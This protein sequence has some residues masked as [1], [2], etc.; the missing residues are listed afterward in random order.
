ME[1][2]TVRV[3]W[4][5]VVKEFLQLRRDRRM[6]PMIFLAPVV[7]ILAFG[8]AVN[9]DVTDVPTLLVDLDRTRA[10]RDLAERFFASGYFRLAG[11][12]DAAAAAEPWMVAGR[13]QMA[14]VIGRGYGEA[15]AAGRSPAIQVVADGSD[16]NSAM[17]GL[18]YASGIV[19]QA[20]ADLRRDRPGGAAPAGARIALEPRVWYNPDLKSRWFYVP[21]VLAMV[22]M[23][24]TL[25]LSAMGIVREK[26]IGTLEQV[27]VTPIRSWQLVAGKLAPFAV[28]GLIDTFLVTAVALWWFRVPLRG[29]L[30]LLVTLTMLFVLNTLGLGLLISTLVRNQQQAMMAATFVVMVPMIYL[31]GLIFPIEN[32]PPAIRW[33]TY[34]IPLRYFAVILRGVFLKGSGLAA[35][36]PQAAALLAFGAGFLALAAARFHKRAA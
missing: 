32:M 31:S 30:G 36:W 28:I 34:A 14:L 3:L 2:L 1:G 19:A 25:V 27:L 26:E 29:S 21:A 22:L 24:M 16:A 4:R 11:T 5:V 10:S 20:S 23:S 35:L 8:Y 33:V 15:I 12:E 18:G 17:V 6:V 7:Q 13:A 9:T